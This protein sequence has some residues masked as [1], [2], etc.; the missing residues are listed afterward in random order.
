MKSHE[1]RDTGRL[2]VL[3][4]HAF[5]DTADPDDI[6]GITPAQARTELGKLER[7]LNGRLATEDG[8]K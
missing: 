8:K 1:A 4:A 3:L 6:E 7:L 5:L 2:A